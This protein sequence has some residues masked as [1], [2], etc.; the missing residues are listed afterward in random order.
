M[1]S[2]DEEAQLILDQLLCLYKDPAFEDIA[3]AQQFL[4][5]FFEASA[6]PGQPPANV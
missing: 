2:Q 4:G 6:T 3:H 5:T 1:C